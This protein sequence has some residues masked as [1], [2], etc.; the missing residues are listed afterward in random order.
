MSYIQTQKYFKN[1][2]FKYLGET[3]HPFEYGSIHRV[4]FSVNGKK[5]F[6]L[7]GTFIP[8]LIG[9]TSYRHVE[10]NGNRKKISDYEYSLLI[11]QM[12]PKTSGDDRA[13]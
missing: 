8:G 1:H 2:S 11:A 6:A 10:T 12:K 9:E 13:T 5:V 4:I 3:S 7:I